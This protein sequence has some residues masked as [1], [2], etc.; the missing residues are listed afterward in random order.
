MSRSSAEDFIKS[1]KYK[2]TVIR[3]EDKDDNPTDGPSIEFASS[4][5]DE[6]IQRA[7][8]GDQDDFRPRTI[9]TQ[10]RPD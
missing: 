4:N 7:N 2:L 10:P 1:H 6:L 5:H 3:V 8:R 9:G